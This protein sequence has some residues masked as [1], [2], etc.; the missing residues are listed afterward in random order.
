[1]TPHTNEAG[2]V[3]AILDED[4]EFI[5]A[6]GENADDL[7]QARAAIAE[8]VEAAIEA[9]LRP[10]AGARSYREQ[11]NR[12]YAAIH[13]MRP[14]GIEGPFAHD[15]PESLDDALRAVGAKP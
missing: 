7:R 12:L 15:V 1:M 3:L 11:M 6:I 9:C 4:A 13:A 2:G 14:D 8:L 5:E 10:H